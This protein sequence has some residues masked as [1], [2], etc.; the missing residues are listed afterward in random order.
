MDTREA[1]PAPEVL[2]YDLTLQEIPF[3]LKQNGVPTKY[4]LRELDGMTRDRHLT[5]V[6]GRSKLGDD[7]RVTGIRDLTNFQA[8]LLVLCVTRAVGGE[9]VT[10]P[11]VQAWPARVQNDLYRRA[12]KLSGIGAEAEKAAK[13]A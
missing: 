10:L 2:E 1:T 5:T 12:E 4:I 13:N 9:P 7:G 8:A 3:T 11:E 6:V